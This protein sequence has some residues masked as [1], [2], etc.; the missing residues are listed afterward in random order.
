MLHLW[1]PHYEAEHGRLS[2]KVRKQLRSISAAQVDRLLA[3]H[4]E[5]VAHCGRSGTKPGSLLKHDIPI[6]TDNWDVTKPGWLE[7]DTVAHCGTSLEGDFIL[8]RHIHR[9]LQRLDVLARRKT[10]SLRQDKHR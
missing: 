1:L 2:A 10:G 3:P 7:A 6:R 8:E 4:K 9:H 5:R